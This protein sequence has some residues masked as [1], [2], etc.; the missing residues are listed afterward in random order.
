MIKIGFRVVGDLELVEPAPH[1][2]W[3]GFL[4]RTPSL[5]HSTDVYKLQITKIMYLKAQT[6][7]SEKMMIFL[8]ET[9]ATT[10]LQLVEP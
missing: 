5:L 2:R 1:Y 7:L 3:T 9:Y 4:V 10:R 6:E 8:H